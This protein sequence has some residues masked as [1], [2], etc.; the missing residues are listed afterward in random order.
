MTLII[1]LVNY[2]IK[3]LPPSK[4]PSCSNFL[5]TSPSPTILRPYPSRKL[6]ADLKGPFDHF[7]S[8]SMVISTIRVGLVS[9]SS[10]VANYLTDQLAAETNRLQDVR[11][12]IIDANQAQKENE[13]WEKSEW[14]A[15]WKAFPTKV[16][17]GL[18]KF[19]SITLC[20]RFYEY[21]ASKVVSEVT[22][23]KLATDTFRAAKR[24]P[25][26]SFSKHME[27]NL[28][29]NS[30][31]FLADCSIYQFLLMYGYYMYYEGKKK[32]RLQLL[33]QYSDN[34][35][36]EQDSGGIA[37]SIILKSTKLSVSRSI[38]LVAASAGGAAG[39]MILPG[40][41]T[42]FGTQLGDSLVSSLTE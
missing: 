34:N 11:N 36:Y 32:K 41:G 21:V 40:W 29:A 17:H 22:L 14:A 23:D 27:T 5:C 37:L 9:S 19:H 3:Q 33:L 30:I 26:R 12:G 15:R 39:T 28:W 8:R 13:E 31:S 7:R 1:P 10:I 35:Q 20:M 6:C 42:L 2:K 25:N 16:C 38:A 4:P 24:E 18:L